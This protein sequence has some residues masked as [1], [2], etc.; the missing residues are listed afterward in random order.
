MTQ[1]QTQV[2]SPPAPVYSGVLDMIG[3]TPMLEL[4]RLETGPCRLFGKLELMNPAGS[5]KDRIGLSMIETA[6]REGKIDPGAD[7]KPTIIEATAGNTGIGLAL[8]AGQRGYKMLVVVPDKMSREKVQHLRAMGAEVVMARSDVSKGHP[9]YYQE[10]AARLAQTTP[11]SFYI[12]QFG[13]P[14]NIE[15][16]YAHTGPEIWDQVMSAT[17]SGVDALVVGVG[18]GG[19]LSGVGRALRERN[20]D[21]KI[22]LADPAGSIL[23]PLVNEGKQVDPGAWLVEGMGEDFVPDICDLNL[24]DEAVAVTDAESFLAARELL[25]LEGVLAGSSTGCLLHAAITWCAR[26]SRPMNVVTFLCD[27][28]AKYLSKMF[29]DYWMIDQGFIQREQTGDLRDLIARRHAE[30]EDHILSPRDPVKQAI[31]S[32]K[33]YDVSQLAVLDENDR[34]VGIIDESDVLL[35]IMAGDQKELEKPVSDIMTSRLETIPPTA[36]VKDLLPIFRADRVAIVVD[37]DGAFL[38]LITRIDLINYLRR[39][40]ATS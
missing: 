1:R 27:S 3:A 29:N 31:A 4:R 23:A 24:V 40:F 13:N 33:L 12:N 8:V 21:V 6:E 16:H 15:A 25:R 19:T 7:P 10:V 34:V 37:G 17:G 14:A 20:S 35:A 22:I 11:N 38:G 5:I 32:M 26:Q 30:R 36:S 39:Q 18:S 28:G 2:Q 9:D